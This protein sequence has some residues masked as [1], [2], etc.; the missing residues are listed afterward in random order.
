MTVAH[1]ISFV[2]FKYGTARIETLQ[3]INNLLNLKGEITYK[4]NIL[5]PLGHM[6]EITDTIMYCIID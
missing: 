1:Q 3:L 4:L 2:H 6:P 5:S